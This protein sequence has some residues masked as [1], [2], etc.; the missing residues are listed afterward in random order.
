MGYSSYL[1][2]RDGIGEEKK[3]ALSLYAGQLAL[4]WAWTPIYFVYHKQGLVKIKLILILSK[5]MKLLL[6][7]YSC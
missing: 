6:H 3:L 5:K 2:L 1:V 4:N 7:F